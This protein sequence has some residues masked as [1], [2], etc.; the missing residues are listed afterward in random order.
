MR[1]H[2]RR[3][4]S[5]DYLGMSLPTELLRRSNS[6]RSKK[7]GPTMLL[8]CR[9]F[10]PIEPRIFVPHG[11]IAWVASSLLIEL[12]LSSIICQGEAQ[13]PIPPIN[14][15]DTYF[16]P[17]KHIPTTEKHIS[18][19]ARHHDDP[20]LTDHACMQRCAVSMKA[21]FFLESDACLF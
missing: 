4:D 9:C 2:L 8:V 7:E 1:K 21:E 3:D 17:V 13:A 10:A 20:Y 14:R 11:R 15:T 5:A 16:I 6:T 12:D 18:L 19:R